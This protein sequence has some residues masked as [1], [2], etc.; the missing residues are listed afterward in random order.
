MF[1]FL[2]FVNVIKMNMYLNVVRG[3]KK[4]GKVYYFRVGYLRVFKE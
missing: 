2:F 4:L 3:N 1:L